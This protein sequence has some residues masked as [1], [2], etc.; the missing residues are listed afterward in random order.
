MK[1]LLTLGVVLT[2]LAE[3][4]AFAASGTWNGTNTNV[5]STSS[6]WSASPAPVAADTATFANAGNGNT[7]ISL[8]G[9]TAA[10]IIFDT[11]SAAAYTLGTGA[12]GSQTFTLSNGNI[13]MNATV[14]TNQLFNA[15]LTL[16]T[17]TTVTDT[18]TNN[19]AGSLTFAGNL[20][21]GS[22][23]VAGTKTLAFTGTGNT[24]VSGVI[25]NGGATTVA[26]TKAGA[27]TLTLSGANSYIGSTSLSAGTLQIS[28]S[29]KLGSTSTPAALAITGGTL[30]LGT[31][32]QTVGAVTMSGN[33]T[34]QN[35]T[36]NGASYA[37]S[38]GTGT[39][40]IISAALT[41]SGVLTKGGAGT[42]TLSGNNSGLSGGVNLGTNGGT[43]N[44]NSATALGTGGFAIG[45]SVNFDN[46]TGAPLTLTTNNVI[47]DNG[48]YTFIGT[49]S[50][51]LGTGGFAV[52]SGHPGMNIANN[53][54]T[55]GGN[56]TGTGSFMT[57]A[58][59]GTLALSG[60]NTGLSNGFAVTAG[61][62]AINSAT[63][64]GTGTL[65]LS[66]GVAIDNTSGAP[67]TLTLAAPESWNTT[68]TFVG[69]ND[70]N[71]GTSAI[72]LANNSTLTTTAGTLTVG[73]VI[74][75][76]NSLTK[77]GNG[78][79]VLSGASTYGG[80][81][82]V[83]AG[84][85][86]VAGAAPSGS[87]GALGN[88]ISAVV[89][90]DA[91]TTTGNFSAS[92]LTGG[93]VTV[94]RQVSIANQ[95]TSGTYA[96][97]GNTNTTSTFS[98]LI[99]ANQ[100]FSVT[101]VATTG[102]N[103][104]T[105]TGG[106]RGIGTGT[107]TITFANTGAVNVTTTAISD[108]TG[109]GTIAVAQGGSGVANLAVASTYTGGTTINAGTLR[110]NNTTGSATGNG[111]VAVKT[112]AF[113]GGGNT[114]TGL[115]SPGGATKGVYAGG[116]QGLITGAVTV[117]GGGH[118]APG[119]S[120]GTI[121]MASLTLNALSQLDYEFNGTA[122]DFSS[123]STTLTLNGGAFNLYQEGT[124]TAFAAAGTYD[125]LSYG[126]LAGTG[127]GAL[128]VANMQAGYSYIFINDTTDKLIQLQI[129]VVPEPGTWAMMLGGLGA[130]VL[131]QRRRA[132]QA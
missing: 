26:L 23:G 67:V 106:M 5:W 56:M 129:A 32:S 60:D 103:A 128:S 73:G 68:L 108:G 97:G 93:A 48:S 81:T 53:T 35:G 16:G 69:T 125:L 102:G 109:G 42:L 55:I 74:S 30:D 86:I 29:G 121:T 2:A 37:I 88:A 36:L 120:V 116:V 111:A 4:P 100:S 21:G 66:A 118:L 78:S 117:E 25:A 22:G 57:K 31:T 39:T 70:L 126:T 131:I 19:G 94:A 85:L 44:I 115:T 54:L 14:T 28:G 79:L 17:A 51:N 96:I 46:T 130:L 80:T 101:Q 124:T 43:L 105:I 49:N 90:G 77:A 47:T 83:S 27:G 9:N 64:L 82:T 99:S 15:N 122:N 40:A 72:T 59:A 87:A 113:L 127:I 61:T 110:V 63:A 107:K 20:T 38:P 91:A 52:G 10:S 65:T 18:I 123:I 62:M 132:K 6:N 33:S 84:N 41:G 3:I 11:A 50:L 71:L 58:G 119:N 13:T 1:N 98:G 104:L 12:V 34:I 75:G 76:V 8:G 114:T 7:T 45:N 92:L 95:A 89:L 112:G 24:S